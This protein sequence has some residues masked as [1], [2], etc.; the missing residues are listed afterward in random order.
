ME[1][2]A[3]KTKFNDFVVV[4]NTLDL[5]QLTKILERNDAVL[6]ET[7]DENNKR[8]R[9]QVATIYDTLKYLK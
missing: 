7:R 1:D 4:P 5:G 2:S 3:I 6:V 8:T 9:L